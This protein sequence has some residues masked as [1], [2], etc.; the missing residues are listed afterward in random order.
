[1][2]KMTNVLGFGKNLDFDRI[3]KLMR[4]GLFAGCI[5]FVGDWILGYGINETGLTGFEGKLS[6]YIGKSDS[7]Y[8]IASIL[9]LFGIFIEGLS[10]FSLYRL[11]AD[12]SQK[13]AHML[14]TGIIGYIAFGAC[15]VHVPCIMITWLYNYLLRVSPASAY[16]CCYKLFFYFI[17]PGIVLFFIFFLIMEAAQ[18]LAFVKGFTPYPKW[19]WI[20]N[21]GLGMVITMCITTPLRGYRFGNA[22]AATWISIGNIWQFAGL[23]VMKNK[24]NN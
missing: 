7:L 1:M 12:K 19:C 23:L 15:G 4:I 2:T 16:D 3:H 17:I 10:Y 9:G 13:Y 22:L 20:F 8:F 11:M 5:V 21:V 18:I 14:R 24:I 6:A